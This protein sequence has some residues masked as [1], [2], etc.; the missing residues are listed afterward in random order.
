[1]FEFNSIPNIISFVLEEEDRIFQWLFTVLQ[2][3]IMSSFKPINHCLVPHRS[4]L[5]AVCSMPSSTESLIL[6]LLMYFSQ[7]I[8]ISGKDNFSFLEMGLKIASKVE[9]VVV[10]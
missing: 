5:G 4:S 8:P 9:V 7:A 1:M 10:V 3:A 2:S 6:K